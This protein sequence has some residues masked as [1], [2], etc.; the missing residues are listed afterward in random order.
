MKKFV[1]IIPFLLILT[2]CVYLFPY[3]SIKYGFDCYNGN[4]TK[5][6]SLININGFYYHYSIETYGSNSITYEYHIVFFEDGTFVFNVGDRGR[7][8]GEKG[9]NSINIFFKEVVTNPNGD[10]ARFFYG[11][12]SFVGIYT[13]RYDT[14]IATA[15]C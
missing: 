9:I 14:I 3:S 1:W 6:V 15:L 5:L 4:T 11:I 12:G 10:A 2:G 8:T 13:I 7:I